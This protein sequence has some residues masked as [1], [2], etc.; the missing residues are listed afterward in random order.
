MSETKSLLA[1]KIR[2]CRSSIA[3]NI[4][5]I[6]LCISQQVIMPSYL[7]SGLLVALAASPLVT[8]AQGAPLHAPAQGCDNMSLAAQKRWCCNY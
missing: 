6:P 5:L 3:Q 1:I 2:R 7:A 4:I 8:L